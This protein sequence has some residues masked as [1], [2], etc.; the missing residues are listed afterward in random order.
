MI[1]REI[2]MRTRQKEM[3]G[4]G[5]GDDIFIILQYNMKGA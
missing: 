3:E 2:R 1:A 4:G 5:A